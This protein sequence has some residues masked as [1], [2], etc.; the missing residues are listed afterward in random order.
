MHLSAPGRVL[1]WPGR[2]E[3]GPWELRK[4][5][6][7]HRPRLLRRGGRARG[8]AAHSSGVFHESGR[9]ASERQFTC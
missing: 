7:R 8:S 5:H 6:L 9:N 4:A 1:P 2:G 3:P